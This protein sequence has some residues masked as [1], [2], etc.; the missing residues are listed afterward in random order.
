MMRLARPSSLPAWFRHWRELNPSRETEP[1]DVLEL[2]L[3]TN[4]AVRAGSSGRMMHHR[5]IF[6][7]IKLG[8]L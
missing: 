7:R 4:V 1:Q 8:K 3:A 2:A 5:F 6:L